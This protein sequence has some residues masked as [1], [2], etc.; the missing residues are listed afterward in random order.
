MPISKQKDACLIKPNLKNYAQALE[1]KANFSPSV[2][3][4]DGYKS[5]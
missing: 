3:A 2:K 1:I 5:D 4:K